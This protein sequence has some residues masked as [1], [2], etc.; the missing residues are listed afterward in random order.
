MK[1]RQKLSYTAFVNKM[2]VFELIANQ[3][4]KSYNSMLECGDIQAS[5]K[6]LKQT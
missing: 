5:S 6:Y 1:V 4:I 3:I 2:T